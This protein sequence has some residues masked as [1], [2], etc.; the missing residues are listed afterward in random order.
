MVPRLLIF[1]IAL[2][3]AILSIFIG[4]RV[5]GP[6]D[7]RTALGV[8][9]VSIN[10]SSQG[11]VEAYVPIADWGVRAYP[12]SAPVTI[13]IEPR[14]VDRQALLAMVDNSSSLLSAAE[15][16]LRS[17]VIVS[18]LRSLFAIM[19]LFLFCRS[20]TLSLSSSWSRE[21]IWSCSPLCRLFWHC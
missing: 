1:L 15:R 4:L 10:P 20:P 14:G 2:L 18:S 6:S 16:D 7:Y 12:F 5:A 9:E 3:L 21:K 11:V 13:H 17:A 8:V 19:F